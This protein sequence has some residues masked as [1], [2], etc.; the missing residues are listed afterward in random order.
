MELLK[1][2]QGRVWLALTSKKIQKGDPAGDEAA[3]KIMTQCAKDCQAADVLG[4][5]LYPHVGFWQE[6]TEVAVRLAVAAKLPSVGVQFNQYHWMVTEGGKNLRET[7]TAALP[8]LK[9]VSINGSNAKPTILP[10]SEGEYDVLPIL[11]VLHELKFEGAIS[12]QGY[13]IQGKVAERL[14]AAKGKW[15]QLSKA[16]RE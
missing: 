8:V 12:H 3:L 16:A 7:L 5:A 2:T 6:K 15:E 9:S 13:S 10:L 4:I 14:E 1:G 11:K